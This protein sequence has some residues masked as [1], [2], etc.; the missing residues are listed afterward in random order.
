MTFH[1]LCTFLYTFYGN[2]IYQSFDV[3]HT[4]WRFF[5][6]YALQTHLD[7]S[8]FIYEI[9]DKNSTIHK[10]DGGWIGLMPL[11]TKFQLYRC[12]QFYWWRKPEYQEKT[13]NLSQVNDKLYHITLYRVH[14]AMN[15]VH[16][17]THKD[18]VRVLGR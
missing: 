16:T 14:L 3:E 1:S 7:I 13:T 11:S 18:E 6:K 8:V 4:Q 12:G 10:D 2:N 15:G 5:Q 9:F 17:H